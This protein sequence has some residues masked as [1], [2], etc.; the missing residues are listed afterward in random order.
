MTRLVE[1]QSEQLSNDIRR[2]MEGAVTETDI[3]FMTD[4]WT[5]LIGESFMTMSTHW[6]TRDWRLKMSILG[7]INFLQEHTAAIISNK[8]MD[9]R[10]EFGV[11]PRSSD[12]RPLQSL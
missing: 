3:V 7:K 1:V 2:E 6:I 8:L 5:S 10:L 4:F 9:L 12:G 11:Y